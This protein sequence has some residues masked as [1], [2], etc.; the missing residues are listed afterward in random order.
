M[1]SGKKFTFSFKTVPLPPPP[2]AL[3]L[4]IVKMRPDTPRFRCCTY[5]NKESNSPMRCGHSN[6]SLLDVYLTKVMY[7]KNC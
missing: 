1:I 3:V 5:H 2:R 7:C 6:E 4:S